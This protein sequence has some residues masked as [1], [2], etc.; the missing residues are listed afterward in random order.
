[1][2]KKIILCAD[3][4][5][6]SPSVS[7]G[8]LKLVQNR[9]LSAVSVLT[10]FQG[11]EQ[12]ARLLLNEQEQIAIGLHMNLTEGKYLSNGEIAMSLNQ[13]LLKSHLRM[14]DKQFIKQ[15]LFA[16]IQRFSEVFQRQPD[17]IDGHQHIHQLPLIR[18][19]LIDYW[20][21]QGNK[22]LWIRSTF[23]Q[24]HSESS[25]WKSHII[26]ATGGKKTSRLLQSQQIPHNAC[27]SGIYN[28]E[29][30][31]N[32]RQLFRDWL[33]GIDNNGLIMCHPAE[34]IE[35]N[36]SINLARNNEFSYFQSAAFIDDL[37]QF[38]VQLSDRP[39]TLIR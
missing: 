35:E 1:M 29:P 9:R 14:I 16:Q 2:T 24:V 15:E 27:F 12:Y 18:E 23:P 38:K 32:Y 31:A 21:Q 4:Y 19:V 6:L 33:Q 5:A 7:N 30:E 36:D 17:F 22:Q 26:A 25:Y 20:Q 34:G 28:F 8:I 11:L 10:N 13:L 3:D 39:S 37:E